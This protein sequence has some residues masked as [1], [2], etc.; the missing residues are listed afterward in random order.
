MDAFAAVTTLRRRN[1][2]RSFS[3]GNNVRENTV[4]SLERAWTPTH[5]YDIEIPRLAKFP[6]ERI[7][8]NP[9]ISAMAKTISTAMPTSP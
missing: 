9:C 1:S 8:A 2:V 6:D 4:Q 7:K 5:K 3:T